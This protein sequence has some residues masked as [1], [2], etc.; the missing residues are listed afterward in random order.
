MKL[1]TLP[2]RSIQFAI[3]EKALLSFVA[4]TAILSSFSG[5]CQTSAEN[6]NCSSGW[7]RNGHACYFV[8]TEQTA[9]HSFWGAKTWCKDHNSRLTTVLS[10]SENNFLDSLINETGLRQNETFYIA[11]RYKNNRWLW[12]YNALFNYTNWFH[13]VEPVPTNGT[14]TNCV[15]YN[16][17][18]EWELEQKCVTKKLFICK[19]E[20]EPQQQDEAQQEEEST[21]RNFSNP[22]E[23]SIPT[24]S[25]S[26]DKNMKLKKLTGLLSSLEGISLTEESANK[27]MKELGAV[28]ND[29]LVSNETTPQPQSVAS[30]T[31]VVEM[32]EKIGETIVKGLKRGGNITERQAI[33]I[34][35]SN[36]VLGVDILPPVSSQ[37]HTNSVTFPQDSGTTNTIN[38]PAS[39]I[40][41]AQHAD[42]V[43]IT[44]LLLPDVTAATD[45]QAK[46]VLNSGLISSTILFNNGSRFNNL[47]VPVVINL[48]QTKKA[49]GRDSRNCVFLDVNTDPPS[50]STFGCVIHE[51]YVSHTV[52]HCYHMTSYAV[53]MDVHGA[54]ES[55]T[56]SGDHALALTTISILG[57]LVALVCHVILFWTFYS[58]RK[59]T[60]TSSIH[61]NL[62]ATEVFAISSFLLAYPSVKIKELCFAIALLL[63]YFQLASF[64]WM[65]VEGINLLR[66]MLKVFRVTG[67]LRIYGFFAWG[68]PALVVAVISSIFHQ[69]FLRSDFCWLSHRLI[70]AFAGPVACILL[71][72]F[73]VLFVAI[74]IVVRRATYKI[75]PAERK[76]MS[77]LQVEIRAAFKTIVILVPLLGLTWFL[78]F[79][80]IH[81]KSLVFQY[82]FAVVNSVQGLYFLIAQYCFDDDMKRNAH[83]ASTRMKML[84]SLSSTK[85]FRSSSVLKAGSFGE[86][87]SGS[88]KK[89]NAV[90][91]AQQGID[92]KEK[93]RCSLAI[94]SEMAVDEQ[95]NDFSAHEMKK[96]LQSKEDSQ[97]RLDEG[98]EEAMNPLPV[99]QK[100]NGNENDRESL[101]D[102]KVDR[103]KLNTL[104]RQLSMEQKDDQEKSEI[105][106]Q[107]SEDEDGTENKLDTSQQIPAYLAENNVDNLV[108]GLE[109][110]RIHETCD[111]PRQD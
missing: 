101:T 22:T 87:N 42:G 100:L 95:G 91:A 109:N 5:V 60:E 108:S 26:A 48:S 57:C 98:Q 40:W 106:E 65:L 73:S 69:T 76:E 83:Q 90:S 79:L 13:G 81:Q 25:E 6:V 29:L 10:E 64:C 78:G 31:T 7:T 15:Y 70:W 49:N 85:S 74:K 2:T 33:K 24:T 86:N 62:A 11:L 16:H 107:R 104:P 43:S 51:Q 32:S 1:L 103:N 71:V 63:Y 94:P 84:F 72:N 18:H 28:L 67:R 38:L 59:R 56:I 30:L 34:Q 66:G 111:S 8:Y 92:E 37:N 102:G 55:D 53:L 39:L 54:Y 93:Q 110:E 14:G 105:H 52:C 75:K 20:H 41:R 35:A 44:S 68:L 97:K 58:I 3:M 82:L 27:Q 89:H 36:L 80:S 9:K 46:R 19:Q 50:W 45:P 17:V 99:A 96:N 88:L 61:M 12:V 23:A 77:D 47:S 4:I 21:A